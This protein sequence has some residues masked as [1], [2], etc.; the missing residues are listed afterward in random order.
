MPTRA[1]IFQRLGGSG[2]LLTFCDGVGLVKRVH[3]PFRRSAQARCSPQEVEE[4]RQEVR[5][6]KDEENGEIKVEGEPHT[7]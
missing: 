6:V 3:A 7:S 5:E 4:V 1:G 2:G